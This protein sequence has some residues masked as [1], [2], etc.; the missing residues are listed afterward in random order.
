MLS[1]VV[2]LRRQYPSTIFPTACEE[3]G[4]EHRLTKVK[5]RWTSGQVERMNR[6]IKETSV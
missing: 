5:H 3:G 4:I 2:E 1:V 6:A